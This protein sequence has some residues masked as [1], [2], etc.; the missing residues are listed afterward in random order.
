MREG[1]VEI[2]A[3]IEN[4][5]PVG[6][7]EFDVIVSKGT[8]ENHLQFY[9]DTDTWKAFGKQLTDFPQNAAE[10]VVFD[11]SHCGSYLDSLL[12][13][14]YCYDAQGHAAL[15]IVV[16]NNEDK[17]RRCKLDFSILAEAASINRLGYFLLNWQ[18]ENGSEIVWEA[19][20]S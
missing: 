5:F 14:A 2:F 12:F 19:Q 10:C 20:T 17:Q 4:Y 9:G 15:R 3:S 13:E 18:V 16:D 1:A 6:D 8:I 7:C 11:A